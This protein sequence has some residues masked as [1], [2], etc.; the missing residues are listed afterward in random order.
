MCIEMSLVYRLIILWHVFKIY[1]YVYK[2]V[3]FFV[4]FFFNGFYGSWLV[5]AI[6]YLKLSTINKLETNKKIN[7]SFWKLCKN[8]MKLGHVKWGKWHRCLWLPVKKTIKSGSILNNFCV[9]VQNHIC[10]PIKRQKYDIINLV[11]TKYFNRNLSATKKKKKLL[12]SVKKRTIL[13][14]CHLKQKFL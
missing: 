11:S 3:R 14:G 4:C 2:R 5:L 6:S 7:I 13:T 10:N 8:L 1:V 9:Y 12:T